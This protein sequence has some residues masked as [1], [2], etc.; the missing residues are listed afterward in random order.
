MSLS[1]RYTRST[2]KIMTNL[3]MDNGKHHLKKVLI[4]LYLAWSEDPEMCIAVDLNNNAYKKDTRYSQL[5]ITKKTI[6]IIKSLAAFDLIDLVNG[7]YRSDGR[8]RKARMWP[9]GELIDYFRKA[10]FNQ[11]YFSDGC[12]SAISR[13]TSSK[14]QD[15]SQT[16]FKSVDADSSSEILLCG[17]LT[18]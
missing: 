7:Y 11:F 15:H 8:S 1:T 12:Y 3:R 17:V 5:H 18:N 4:D 6:P 16:E 14:T 9:T 10:E 2:S 13:K